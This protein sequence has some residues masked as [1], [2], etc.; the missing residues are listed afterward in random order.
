M[1]GWRKRDASPGSYQGKVGS[2]I[3]VETP[4]TR[5]RYGSIHGRMAR[6]PSTQER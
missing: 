5:S 3:L 1:L 4:N 6:G 2:R